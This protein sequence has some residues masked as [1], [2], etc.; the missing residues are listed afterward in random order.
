MFFKEVFGGV[1]R[2]D[3]RGNV[4]LGVDIVRWVAVMLLEFFGRVEVRLCLLG[5]IVVFRFCFYKV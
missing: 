4:W 2:D 1:V 5:Y 3:G